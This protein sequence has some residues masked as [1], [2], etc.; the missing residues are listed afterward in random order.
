MS[1]GPRRVMSAT[2]RENAARA[3]S[4]NLEGQDAEVL[5]VRLSRD[6]A[7]ASP[8]QPR[9][10]TS[11]QHL[12]TSLSR[13]TMR[14]GMA[15]AAGEMWG[16]GG[17][18]RQQRARG[19]RRCSG[20]AK[21]ARRARR[22]TESADQRG[23]DGCISLLSH[24]CASGA[25]LPGVLIPSCRIRR[26]GFGGNIRRRAGR[27]RLGTHACKHRV[28]QCR[29]WRILHPLRSDINIQMSWTWIVAPR[30]RQSSSRRRTGIRT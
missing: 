24:C 21:H 12:K 16:A 17:G 3:P 25:L 15:A 23:Q 30:R 22:P 7:V 13:V 6:F 19:V 18:T 4:G 2:W 5:H 10:R 11:R 29:T 20:T 9:V 27:P 1:G 14:G 28:W 26:A 8:S